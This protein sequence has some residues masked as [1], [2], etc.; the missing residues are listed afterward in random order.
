[1]HIYVTYGYICL[2]WF[3]IVGSAASRLTG[4]YTNNNTTPTTTTTSKP[5][6]GH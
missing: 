2:Q 3:D 4:P 1:M 6:N 5:E